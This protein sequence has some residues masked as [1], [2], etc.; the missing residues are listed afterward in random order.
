MTLPQ[1]D[2]IHIISDLHMGG[3]AGFQILRETERLAAFVRW[4]ATQRPDGRVALILNGDVIDTLAEETG[5]YIAVDNAVDV[6]RRIM[7][8]TAFRPIWDALAELVDTPG[9]SLVF[10]LGNHDLELAFPAVQ[11]AVMERLAGDDPAARGRITFSTMGAGY[12]C[13]VGDKRVFCTHGNEVDAWNYI[14]YEDLAKAGRRLNCGRRLKP[15]EWE[16]NAGTKMVKDVMNDIKRSFPWIDLLKPETKAAVGVLIAIDSSQLGKLRHILPVV[17]ER[18][19]GGFEVDRRLSAE[20]FQ[21]PDDS[22]P[23][24][25]GL[26][27]LL[28]PNLKDSVL[29]AGGGRPAA[30]ELLYKAEQD[31]KTFNAEDDTPD[32]TLGTGQYLWDR[33]TGWLTGVTDAEALRRALTDW[34]EGDK[35]F[36]VSDRD[37]TC[38]QVLDSIGGHID[39]IVTGHTHLERAI[40]L[41]GGRVYFN[42]GT[43]IRLLRFTKNMLKDEDAF[44]PVFAFLKQCTMADLD[45]KE[46]DGKPFILDHCGAVC[47]KEEGGSVSGGLFHIK[48][49]AGAITPEPVPSK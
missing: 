7:D 2:E 39:F 47:I 46:F 35:S 26:D 5:G 14:R 34:L 24:Q 42:C 36:D 3:K 4:V 12:A 1:H 16:P 6:V 22:R 21:A 11:V 48:E 18:I 32:E 33:L 27:H 17:G 15:A 38:T 8:D 10:V 20:G 29:S 37:D 31:Y 43:W 40:D 23:R 49:K 13:R 30:V 9:R 19:E 41:S 44:K 45:Q 25:V 28:G